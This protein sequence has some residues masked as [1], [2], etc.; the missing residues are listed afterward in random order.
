[1]KTASDPRHLHREKLV[2][3]LYSYSFSTK[4][5]D[6][7]LVKEILDKL[8]VIDHNITK[9]ASEWPIEK[10]NRLDLAVLRLAV[11]EILSGKTPVKV[12]VDEAIELAKQ[13]GS[14]KSP[15]FVNGALGAILKKHGYK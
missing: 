10:I 4:G 9:A 13:Y 5:T 2:Q 7:K 15:Q 8:P 3:N 14:E 12:I 1:M 6:L 11:F